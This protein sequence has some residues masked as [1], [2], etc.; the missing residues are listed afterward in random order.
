MWRWLTLD[1]QTVSGK[2]YARILSILFRRRLHI[3]NIKTPRLL[4]IHIH[5]LFWSLNFR[6]SVTVLFSLADLVLLPT[7]EARWKKPQIVFGSIISQKK[8]SQSNMV[9]LAPCL[10]TPWMINIINALIH[11]PFRDLINISCFRNHSHP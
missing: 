9:I 1:W 11:W 10:G 2:L 8:L 4:Q 3:N 5:V 7:L 6:K